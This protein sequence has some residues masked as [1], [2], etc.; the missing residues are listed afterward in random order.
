MR[1]S[2]IKAKLQRGEPALVTTL[3]LIDP[4]L[5]EM[6]SLMGFDGIWMD[7]EHHTYSL[8]TGAG[9]MRAARVGSADIIARPAK[10]EFM[11]MQRMLEAGAQGIMYPRC[12]DAREA[13]EVVGWA[14]FAPQGRRGCDAANPDAPYLFMPVADYVAEANRQTFVMIQIESPEALERADEIAAVEG[15]DILF[16]GPGDYSILS[17]FPGQMNDERT[18]QAKLK[19]A[20]AA[21]RA[22]KNW[23]CPV[24]SPEQAKELME[25]GARLI[26]YQAD[27]VM[28]KTGLEQIQR[29]MAPLGFTFG[30][31]V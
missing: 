26:C 5:F 1:P 16:L 27:I 14:K 2:R 9:L 20:E 6:T 18:R 13:A 15:V 28:I 4:S 7:M 30:G 29:E 31:G 8:E 24:G 17:G 22:G 25:M 10:G 23:G 19:V 3:H 21:R 11:R 12:D